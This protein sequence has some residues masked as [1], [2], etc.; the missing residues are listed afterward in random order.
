MQTATHLQF[1]GHCREAFDRY[2]RILGGRIALA[3]TYGDTPG[4]VQSKSHAR[5][6]IAHARLEIG[7]QA[8]LG[9]D[10]PA[11]RYQ[12]PQ[13][14]NVMV[15]FDDPKAAER[16]FGALADGGTV[17]MPFAETFWA[18]RFGMCNDHFGIPWM[19]NCPKPAATAEAPRRT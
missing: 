5:D 10:V 14:F 3:L 16:V 2:A 4:R 7:T 9:C 17:T 12:S 6:Q 1:R 13:G 11:E 8:L 18:Q 19:V 15:E